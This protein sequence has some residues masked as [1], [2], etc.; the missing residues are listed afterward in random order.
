M[1]IFCVL[2]FETE[3]VWPLYT[4]VQPTVCVRLIYKYPE[5]CVPWKK[6]TR[7][8]VFSLLL[9]HWYMDKI[10]SQNRHQTGM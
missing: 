7:L 2:W 1:L 5:T 8:M 3:N 6:E 9:P 4:T 10:T